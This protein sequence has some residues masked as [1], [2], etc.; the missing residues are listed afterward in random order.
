MANIPKKASDLLKNKEVNIA[1]GTLSKDNEPNVV[2]INNLWLKDKETILIGDVY[3][4]KTRKNLKEKN[5][6]SISFWKN[7]E[8]YQIKGK[9]SKFINSGTLFKEKKKNLEKNQDLK[10]EN[11]A[12]IKIE[13]V[14]VT[15]PGSKAGEK[16]T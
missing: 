1:L 12:I 6:V 14:Y 13:E 16:I 9:I 4:K 11:L 2:P 7:T 10:L 8:G 3:F 5:I 15:S